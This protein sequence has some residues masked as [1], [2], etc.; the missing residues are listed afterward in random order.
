[1]TSN[2]RIQKPY[3]ITTLPRP[4]DRPDGKPGRYVC[5]EVF[6]QQRGSARK[7]KRSEI[8]V[9]IDGDAVNLYDV[10]DPE[11]ED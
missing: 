9:G 2:L 5:G 11:D 1:M 6:G 8:S 3:V 4:L 10:C 7:R